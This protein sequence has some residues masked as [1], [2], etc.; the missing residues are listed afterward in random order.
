MSTQRFTSA[1]GHVSLEVGQPFNPFR[2]FNGIFIPDALVRAM[3]LS[4]GGKITYGRL[5]RYAGEDGECYPA[6]PTLACEIGTSE[7]QTQRYLAELEKKK[8]IKRVPRIT[9]S[10]QS[11]N[12]FVFLWHPIFVHAAKKMA[13]E[14]VTNLSPEGVTDSSP[15]ESQFEESQ[16]EETTNNKRIPGHASQKQRSAASSSVMCSQ[17]PE[18]KPPEADAEQSAFIDADPPS[19][20]NSA[21][22]WTQEELAGV[23]HRIVAFWGREPEEGFE[24]SVMLRA[25]GASAAAVCDLFDRKFANKNLRVGGRRAP[26]SQNWFLAVIE[27]E[28]TPGHLPEPPSPARSDQQQREA[29]IVKRG[30]EAIELPDAPRS[31]VESVNCNHCGHAAMVLYTDGTIEACGCRQQARGGLIRAASVNAS[32][33]HSPAVLRSPN[34]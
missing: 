2:L 21:K 4:P 17:E 33:H 13:L 24:V 15:K 3:G 32:E 16:I 10:G 29:D 23:R 27:N 6:V 1:A 18:N 28:F 9:E 31:I 25:R 22:G 12:G 14:G 11:S 8:L 19:A 26:R 34:K 20:E 7:R 30:I 5:S